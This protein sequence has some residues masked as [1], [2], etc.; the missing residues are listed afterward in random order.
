MKILFFGTS[1]A[2]PSPKNGYTSFLVSLGGSRV[3]VDTGDNPVKSLR[4]AGE[5]PL[6][7]DAI[8]LTHRHVDHLGSFPSLVSA[9]DCMGR[10]K[11]LLVIAEEN[12]ADTARKLLDVFDAGPE[13]IS[14][15]IDYTAG[16]VNIPGMDRGSITLLPGKHSVPTSMVLFRDGAEGLLYTSDYRHGGEVTRLAED[17]TALVHEATYPH[18]NLP[19]PTGHSSAFEAGLAARETGVRLLFLCHLY[20]DAYSRGAGS[21]REARKVFSGEIISPKLLKWY[22]VG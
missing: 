17:C 3:L 15:R 22:T 12:T 10:G 5:D 16:P 21:V 8:V 19:D 18:K 4:E 14:F 1:G 6:I 20:R 7:L 11:K 2:V 13:K 9:L